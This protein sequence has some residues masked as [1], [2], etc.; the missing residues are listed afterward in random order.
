MVLTDM[1]S[2]KLHCCYKS[3]DGNWPRQAET[4][5]LEKFCNTPGSNRC[6]SAYTQTRKL[7]NGS[8]DNL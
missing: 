4:S 2:V 6:T 8:E 3:T 1:I 5:R 7:A